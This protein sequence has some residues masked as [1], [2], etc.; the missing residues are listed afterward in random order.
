[1]LRHINIPILKKKKTETLTITSPTY[2]IGKIFNRV[3]KLLSASS[4]PLPRLASAL[5]YCLPPL[6]FLSLPSSL[7]TYSSLAVESSKTSLLC[8]P[9]PIGKWLQMRKRLEIREL[10]LKLQS[11]RGR[12]TGHCTSDVGFRIPVYLHAGCAPVCYISLLNFGG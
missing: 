2:I 9:T 12:G 4:H 7:S 1:M 8:W 11:G 10:Q 3:T 5:P 6:A